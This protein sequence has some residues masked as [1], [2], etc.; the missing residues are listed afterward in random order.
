MVAA[1]FF[2]VLDQSA[3]DALIFMGSTHADRA[4]FP[5]VAVRI[6]CE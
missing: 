1:Q 4:Q 2:G 5:H 6:K 3:A